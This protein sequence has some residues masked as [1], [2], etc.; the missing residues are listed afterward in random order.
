MSPTQTDRVLARI[1]QLDEELKEIRS[2]L[3]AARAEVQALQTGLHV[4]KWVMGI[5][6]A[7]GGL[8]VSALSLIGINQ[9]S[10]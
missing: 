7:I 2:D 1:D 9:N 10:K 8:V 6:L 5:L 4:G 3:A